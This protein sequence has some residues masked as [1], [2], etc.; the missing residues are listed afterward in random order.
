MGSLT[1]SR[2]C[3]RTQKS[4]SGDALAPEIPTAQCS[5]CLSPTPQPTVAS[6]AGLASTLQSPEASHRHLRT[7]PLLH[8]SHG[9][10]RLGRQKLLERKPKN[11]Q[12][13]SP[14][15]IYLEMQVMRLSLPPR[16]CGERG[17]RLCCLP[18]NQQ[19]HHFQAL[20]RK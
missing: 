9:T 7:L 2:P 10:H 19:G 11:P 8:L 17:G 18:E 5:V 3:L 4:D 15:Q 13:L 6:M 14:S 20:W 1:H 12:L 16:G